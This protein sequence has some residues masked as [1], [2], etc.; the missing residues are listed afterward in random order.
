[1]W[2][3]QTTTRTCPDCSKEVQT[4]DFLK[5]A[6]LPEVLLIYPA[7]TPRLGS[8][9]VSPDVRFTYPERLDMS[10][11]RDDPTRPGDQ[12]DCVY[13]LESIVTWSIDITEYRYKAALRQDENLWYEFND[14]PRPEGSMTG[15]TLDEIRGDDFHK[16][17]L[18]IY[19]RERGAKAPANVQSAVR[20]LPI[21]PARPVLHEPPFLTSADAGVT[22][23]P[24]DLER[25]VTAQYDGY[26][27]GTTFMEARD[28]LGDG[29]MTGRWIWYIFPVMSGL[30]AS[31]RCPDGQKYTIESLAEARAYW[32]HRGLR[33][34]YM[35][36]LNVVWRCYEKHPFALFGEIHYMQNFLQSLTLFMLICN[37]P[38]LN[39]FHEV[40]WKFFQGRCDQITAWQLLRWINAEGDSR[41]LQEAFARIN[42]SDPLEQVPPP[43]NGGDENTPSSTTGDQIQPTVTVTQP[44]PTTTQPAVID[45]QPTVTTTQPAINTVEPAVNNTTQPRPSHNNTVHQPSP[46]SGAGHRQ[47]GLNDDTDVFS[48]TGETNDAYEIGSVL[49]ALADIKLSPDNPLETNDIGALNDQARR[50]GHTILDFAHSLDV[51]TPVPTHATNER[52][53][54]LGRH[55]IRAS[56]PADLSDAQPDDV[57]DASGAFEGDGTFDAK[58]D[59]GSGDDPSESSILDGDDDSQPNDEDPYGYVAIPT[60]P[61]DER[62]LACED[63]T[64]A[65]YRAAFHDEGLDWRGLRND[66]GKYQAKFLKHFELERD[67]SIYH[68]TKLRK[69][70]REKISGV[71]CNA[72][73]AELVEVLT[74][75]DEDILQHFE[76]VTDP[77]GSEETDSGESTGIS[78]DYESSLAS[79]TEAFFIGTRRDETPGDQGREKTA[80]QPQVVAAPAARARKRGRD[81]DYDDEGVTPRN[82]P[83]GPRRMRAL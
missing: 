27:N 33:E 9:R 54:R 83:K 61:N 82:G 69:V 66:A 13:K 50:L 20:R 73:K 41:A 67:Y 46:S 28:Q 12:T 36:I 23:D 62:I 3:E 30:P 51:P 52:A 78:E 8:V 40:M 57:H 55:L 7:F 24:Y 64:L 79:G 43:R 25:F 1:M 2:E 17:W 76:Y 22:S 80:V 16:P 75:Y 45:S 4:N 58:S 38:E 39:V 71:K 11:L 63:W 14:R 10:D 47:T 68:E 49:L 32:S 53:R 26:E 48:G 37:P 44:T 5:Y 31:T 65:E 77:D 56:L 15:K 42:D 59:D 70:V 74:D 21:R 60:D 18:L 81:D 34:R 72:N 6:Y 19:V 35:E 29:R